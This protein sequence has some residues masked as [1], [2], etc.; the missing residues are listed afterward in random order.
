M[1]FLIRLI[2]ISLLLLPCLVSGQVQSPSFSYEEQDPKYK[3]NTNRS[4]QSAGAA[5]S[6]MKFDLFDGEIEL[7][8]FSGQFWSVL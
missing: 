4:I 2:F 3:Y 5:V 7:T 6:L 1:I 8:F